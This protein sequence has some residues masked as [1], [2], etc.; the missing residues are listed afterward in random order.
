M[1]NQMR[2]HQKKIER[3]LEEYPESSEKWQRWLEYHEYCLWYFQ[4]GRNVYVWIALA[5]LVSVL[6]ILAMALN[7]G[8]WGLW[9]FE[10]LVFLAFLAVGYYGCVYTGI[11]HQLEEQAERL[12][13]KA[14][15]IETK[16]AVTAAR[17]WVDV[18]G[19]LVSSWVRKWRDWKAEN[20]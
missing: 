10:W 8:T 14:E 12:F 13:E 1:I 11:L 17:Y 20:D 6:V 4:A 16:P 3:L 18:A 19:H 9:V 15:A 5:L 2:R 7:G